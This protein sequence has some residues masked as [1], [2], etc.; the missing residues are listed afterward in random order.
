ME[1]NATE[2]STELEEPKAEEGPE[3]S[4]VPAEDTDPE[5]SSEPESNV[6]RFGRRQIDVSAANS[7][8]VSISVVLTC[9]FQI[10]PGAL[11]HAAAQVKVPTNGGDAIL[12]TA[13]GTMYG[14]VQD[15]IISTQDLCG[16]TVFVISSPFATLMLHV[17]ERRGDEFA[18]QGPGSTVGGLSQAVMDGAFVGKG[19]ELLIEAMRG[20]GTTI[21]SFREWFPLDKTTVAVVTPKA[22]PDYLDWDFWKRREDNPEVPPQQSIYMTEELY[23]SLGYGA[24]PAGLESFWWPL[25]GTA[26]NPVSTH[27][28]IAGSANPDRLVYPSAAKALLA[29]INELVIPGRSGQSEIFTYRRR[30]SNDPDHKNKVDDR[31]FVAVVPYVTAQ[32]TVVPIMYYDDDKFTILNRL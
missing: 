8:L 13:A 28:I 25:S 6:R 32:G 10:R 15:R 5:T 27:P 21:A 24:W 9:S 3:A 29:A 20:F 31:E 14:P 1:G 4:A 16:C 12:Y 23:Q 18:F 22:N 26:Q 30:Y 11:R 17:L 2:T 7:R 19:R